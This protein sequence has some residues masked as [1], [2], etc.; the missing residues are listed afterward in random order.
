MNFT[1]W[2][3]EIKLWNTH[4]SSVSYTWAHFSCGLF[5]ILVTF[6]PS[7]LVFP[8]LQGLDGHPSERN[9]PPQSPPLLG[10]Q[11]P[12][13]PPHQ[14]QPQPRDPSRERL[15]STADRQLPVAALQ[16]LLPDHSGPADRT[17]DERHP[18]PEAHGLWRAED[19]SAAGN[20]AQEATGHAQ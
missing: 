1:K 4:E 19:G 3:W 15:P 13:Q 6:A 20:G 16:P 2:T 9:L 11:P 12:S 7:L 18:V 10:P 8:S 17:R 14:Q 5:F